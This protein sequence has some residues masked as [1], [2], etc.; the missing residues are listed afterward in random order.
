MNQEQGDKGL[1]EVTGNLKE[2][3]LVKPEKEEDLPLVFQ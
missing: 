3:P 1:G 2:F